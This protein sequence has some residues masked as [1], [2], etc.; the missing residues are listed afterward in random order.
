MATN[1]TYVL[2]QYFSRYGTHEG[3]ANIL[4]EMSRL[5]APPV[6]DYT[7]DSDSG[8]MPVIDVG[9][10]WLVCY[11]YV[12]YSGMASNVP[13]EIFSFA[14]RTL[15]EKIW[16]EMTEYLGGKGI[17]IHPFVTWYTVVGNA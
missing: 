15:Q 12:I 1:I 14:S 7:W 16:N 13:P 4:D 10:G 8:D 9:N 11:R 3:V 6:T 5:S 2:G 17:Y